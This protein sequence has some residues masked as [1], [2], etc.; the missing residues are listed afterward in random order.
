MREEERI[1]ETANI[2]PGTFDGHIKPFGS[3]MNKI[4]MG[5]KYEYKYDNNPGPGEYDI[6]S[7]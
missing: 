7:P 6:E 4:G 2:G 5:S 1:A 3:N